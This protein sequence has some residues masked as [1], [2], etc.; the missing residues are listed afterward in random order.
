[1]HN[2]LDARPARR[3]VE[4]NVATPLARAILSGKARAGST[5][6]MDIEAGQISLAVSGPDRRLC[7]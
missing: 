6:A 5:V 7:A 2:Q 3:A 4:R 1:M